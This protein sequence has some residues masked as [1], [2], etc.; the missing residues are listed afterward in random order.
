M[1]HVSKQ[2]KP[3]KSIRHR[4]IE[5]A[6][7]VVIWEIVVFWTFQSKHDVPIN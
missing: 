7:E 3:V 1:Q 5:K 6:V 4:P 2:Y